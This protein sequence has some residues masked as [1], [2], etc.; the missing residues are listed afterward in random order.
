M[1]PFLTQNLIDKGVSQKNL[2]FIII[3]LLA[4]IS[5]YIGNL[6]IGIIRNWITLF[7]G[8]KMSVSI[9]S[10]FL[11]RLLQ[12]PIYFFERKQK[13]DFHQ[14]ILDN[15][16]IEYFLT[17]QSL[18]TFFSIISFFIYFGILWYYDIL[19]IVVYVLLTLISFFWSL[20]WLKKRKI[21]DYLLF[22]QKIK[23]QESIYEI[24]DGVSE[25]KL[26]QFDDFKRKE[27]EKYSTKII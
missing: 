20:Y 17:S 5:L 21:L 23:S 12:L 19:I 4:Q 15:D 18:F 16:R 24:I 26:N 3:I 13:G 9:I 27:W 22:N 11:K 1:F 8:T 14:R 2:H 7:M 25:M 6:S 10:D